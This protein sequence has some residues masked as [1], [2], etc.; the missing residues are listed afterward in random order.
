MRNK[1]KKI[2]VK[3]DTKPLFN[4]K[5]KCL[6]EESLLAAVVLVALTIS[7]IVVFAL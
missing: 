4:V 5:R 7:G 1:W 3:F 2:V 6:Q